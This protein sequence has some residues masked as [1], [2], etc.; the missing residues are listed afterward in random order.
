MVDVPPSPGR[1][2]ERIAAM[3]LRPMAIVLTHGHVDHAAGA[4]ALLATVGAER[5]GPLS[6]QPRAA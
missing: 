6:L 4:A 5:P 1:L 2:A 3:E